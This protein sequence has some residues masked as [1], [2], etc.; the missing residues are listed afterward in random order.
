MIM[1]KKRIAFISE[2][3][4]P[5]V[6]PGGVDAGGQNV[7]VAELAKHLSKLNYVI[8]IFTRW[9]DPGTPQVINWLPDIRVIHITAG[10]VKYIA[11]D[12]LLPFMTE[13]RENLIGFSR[14]EGI[15]YDLVHAHFW[16]SA[17]V[18]MELKLLFSTPFTVTFHGLGRI[19]QIHQPPDE[20]FPV[21]RLS[22]EEQVVKLAD[23]LIAVCPQDKEDLIN[24]YKADPRKITVIPYGVN[25]REFH[26][27]D[28]ITARTILGIQ[29]D[30]FVVLQICR[31]VPRKGIDNIIRAI[32]KAKHLTPK[33]RLVVVGGDSAVPDANKS[34]EIGRLQQLAT[35]EGV[36]DQVTFTGRKDRGRLKYYYSAAN[37]FVTTPWYEPFGTTTLEA[38][39]CGTPVIGSDVGGL[40]FT[41]DHGKTGFL[42]PPDNPE[43]LAQRIGELMEDETILTS[44]RRN[45]IKRVHTLFTWQNIAEMIAAKYEQIIVTLFSE[46]LK[47]KSLGNR[48]QP[49]DV[50]SMK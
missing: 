22:I 29:K 8:D 43:L 17:L 33:I 19:R 16:M 15:R 44:M 5:L 49:V 18:A 27:L 26:P 24:Y 11:K 32:A 31:M 40:K 47:K 7:Y 2:H 25:V 20:G 41:I 35:K 28:R 4:S 10:P 46:M 30:E 13:F 48:N 37:V 23:H 39:A 3:A 38:M 1:K 6:N 21:E 50:Y 14:T 9:D 42:L 36:A 45:A 34:P 12:N